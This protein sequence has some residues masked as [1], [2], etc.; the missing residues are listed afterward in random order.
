RDHLAGRRARV[1]HRVS[2]HA[3]LDH[4][5]QRCGELARL[6]LADEAR[7]RLLDNLVAAEAEQLRDG[8]VR[9]EDLALEV[10]HEHRVGRV[11]D[12]D[13]RGERAACRSA[14]GRYLGASAHGGQGLLGHWPVLRI[15]WA[16]NWGMPG[17][18]CGSAVVSASPASGPPLRL[19]SEAAQIRDQVALLL[20]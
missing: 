6:V 12:D 1:Q 20:G 17:S 5:A 9:L 13:V 14:V 4:L 11:L 16:R 3:A 18:L 19:A 7:E 10:G 15:M 8:V 2:R